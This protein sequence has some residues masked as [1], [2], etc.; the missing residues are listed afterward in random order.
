[1]RLTPV[2]ELLTGVR[3]FFVKEMIVE[4]TA[5]DYFHRC[6]YVPLSLKTHEASS[7]FEKIKP[8]EIS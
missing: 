1:M 5:S 2:N 7:R 4:L 3:H 8:G 6:L